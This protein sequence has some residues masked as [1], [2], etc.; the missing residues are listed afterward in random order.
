MKIMPLTQ[1]HL[2][3]VSILI[4]KDIF[5]HSFPSTLIAKYEEFAREANLTKELANPN[6][7]AFVSVYDKEVLGFIFGYKDLE[8]IT[9]IRYLS[10][11]PE[12]KVLLLDKFIK[13]AKKDFPISIKTDA[14]QFMANKNL[15]TDIGFKLKRG[16]EYA[17]VES[18]SYELNLSYSKA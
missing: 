17:N 11:N 6:T 5:Q 15:L 3:K 8:R 9:V 12:S 10:G 4:F 14:F 18:L 7:I 1:E 16:N 2:N 13:E